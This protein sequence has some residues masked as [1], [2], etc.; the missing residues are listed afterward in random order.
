MQFYHNMQDVT[1]PLMNTDSRSGC[2]Y[3]DNNKE[4]LLFMVI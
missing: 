4:P 1:P 3:H 2:I